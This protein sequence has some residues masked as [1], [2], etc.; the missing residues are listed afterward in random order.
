ML[1][2]Q[3]AL[4]QTPSQVLNSKIIAGRNHQE[5]LIFIT[6]PFSTSPW[7]CQWC[8]AI[9]Y[10]LSSK[11]VHKAEPSVTQHLASQCDKWILICLTLKSGPLC[12]PGEDVSWLLVSKDWM[13]FINN[14]Q[15]FAKADL[16][17]CCWLVAK[18]C[19]TLLNPKDCSPPGSSV[20]RIFEARVLEWVVISFC[21]RP[22]WPRD[23]ALLY[24]ISCTGRQIRFYCVTWEG[25]VSD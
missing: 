24:C 1:I 2:F 23:W 25:L 16:L 15:S 18:L 6:S 10:T 14:I 3:Y 20:H 21:R 9:S 5:C 22:S 11:W 13:L 17:L 12:V 19:P 4:L 7:G 8:T